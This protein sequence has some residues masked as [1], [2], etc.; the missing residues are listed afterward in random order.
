MTWTLDDLR[1]AN[2]ERQLE[3]CEDRLPDLSFRAMELAGEAGEACNVAKKIVRERYGWRGSRATKE[4]L[5]QELA[6]VIIC[7]S[8]VAGTEGIDLME[9]VPAKFNQTSDERG[10]STKL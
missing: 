2:A 3:W 6:D 7:C 5:A 8:L 4:Q 1:E 9:A 10:L